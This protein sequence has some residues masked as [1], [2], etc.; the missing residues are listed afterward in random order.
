MAEK[1]EVKITGGKIDKEVLDIMKNESILDSIKDEKQISRLILNCFCEFLS[2]IR[3]LRK[4]FDEFSQM[5][6]ICSADKL[7]EFFKELQKNVDVESKKMEIYEKAH[8]DHKKSVK[9]KRKTTKLNKNT[10]K[11]IKKSV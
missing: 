10:Q 7:A 3:D 11:N 2:E 1:E 6:S 5:I 8:N 9:A 4:E